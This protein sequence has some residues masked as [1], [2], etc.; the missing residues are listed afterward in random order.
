MF[1]QGASGTTLSGL[2]YFPV[3]A[4][5]LDGA[6]SVGNGTGQCLQL[7]GKEVTLAGG[8]L[9]A[10]TCISGSSAG[11]RVVLVR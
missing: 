6:A 5:R 7:I 8:S 9:L 1:T 10:S 3:G 4:V 2:F 11:G